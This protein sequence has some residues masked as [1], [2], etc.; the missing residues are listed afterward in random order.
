MF[1]FANLDRKRLAQIAA[2]VALVINAALFVLVKLDQIA[3]DEQG[4][5]LATYQQQLRGPRG[6][7]DPEVL[8]KELEA[9]QQKA[10]QAGADFPEQVDLIAL[11]DHLVGAARS[12]GVQLTSLLLQPPATRQ[13]VG[14][15]Y[16]VSIIGVEGRGD[17]PQ[18]R[19]FIDQ[20]AIGLYQTSALENVRLDS[21][22]APQ[23]GEA[24]AGSG[25][26]TPVPSPVRQPGPA[27]SG[28]LVKFDMVVYGK[29]A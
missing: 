16:P 22:K 28:W 26:A 5:L 1:N 7:V 12:N 3:I 29:P 6:G 23:P 15:T 9:A 4:D 21:G 27:G 19:S 14:G 25:P 11:Q 20:A 2:A 24:S 10:A 8:N 17:L 18:L 13:L